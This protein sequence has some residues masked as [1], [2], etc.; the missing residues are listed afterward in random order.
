MALQEPSSHEPGSGVVSSFTKF[1]EF[2]EVEQMQCEPLVVSAL[3]K[4]IHALDMPDMFRE[5]C[6]S[7]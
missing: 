5:A 2:L 3:Y 7:H 6:S 4:A 1:C